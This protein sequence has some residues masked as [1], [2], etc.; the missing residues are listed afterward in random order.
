MDQVVAI[1]PK[2]STERVQVSL[3]EFEGHDLIDLRIF[4]SKD[5]ETWLPSKKG[6][7]LNVHKLPLL[8]G[9]LHKAAFMVGEAEPETAEEELLSPVERSVLG[10]LYGLPPDDVEE[11][12]AQK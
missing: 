12:A 1:I 6:V 5:R 10:E 8:L 9:A 2:H 11:I 3:R 7:S 4:W